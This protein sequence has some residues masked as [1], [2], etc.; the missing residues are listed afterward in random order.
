MNKVLIGI[1]TAPM[2]LYGAH[3]KAF[4][5]NEWETFHRRWER[6][7]GRFSGPGTERQRAV[8]DTWGPRIAEQGATFKFFVGNTHEGPVPDD[9]VKLD[10]PDGYLDLPVKI[11]AMA[12]WAKEHDYGILFKCDDDTAVYPGLVPFLQQTD[13]QYGGCVYNGYAC[14]GGPGYIWGRQTMDA[15]LAVDVTKVHQECK[16]WEDWLFAEII[17]DAG[18]PAVNVVGIR[19]EIN[20]K[21]PVDYTFHPVSPKGM[22]QF[23]EEVW[24]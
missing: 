20:I 10:V 14:G 7:W 3:E 9:T 19:E 1:P 4:Q 5:Y 18:I 21:P 17:K 15:V 2:L 24:K 22:R 13:I 12:R 16:D 11:Q 6:V 8:R 23:Y